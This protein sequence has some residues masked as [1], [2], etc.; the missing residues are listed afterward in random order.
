M[1]S[2]GLLVYSQA[3][4]LGLIADL[5]ESGPRPRIRFS[6]N[7]IYISDILIIVETENSSI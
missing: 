1:E 7:Y 2:K 3:S 6:Y 4:A 5:V